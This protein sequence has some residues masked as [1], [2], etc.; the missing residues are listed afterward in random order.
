M[1]DSNH[2]Q[3]IILRY[4]NGES[5]AE[6]T[7]ELEQWKAENASHAEEF[8]LIKNI[9][10]DASSSAIISV[11]TEK[12]WSNVKTQ[13][14][15]KQT[16]VVKLFPWKRTLAV[17]ASLLLFVGVYY[18]YFK[19]GTTVW[20]ETL[21]LTDNKSIQLS[22]GTTVVLR[23][24][25]KLYIPDD[26][27]KRNRQTKLEGEAYFEVT[28]DAQIPFSVIT[29]RSIIKD[30]GTAFFVQS[31][32]RTEQVTVLE[33]IISYASKQENKTQL[34]LNAGESAAMEKEKPKKIEA[35]TTNILSWESKIL[36]FSNTPLAL[37]AEDLSNYYHIEVEVAAGI[38]STQITATF[39][40]ESL[41]QV[42]QELRL[43]SGLQFR[44]A[45][46]KLL[47]TK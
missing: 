5:S 22:D 39:K 20:T 19:Q 3:E 21:A 23:K 15:D 40:N 11:D 38:G 33:G 45:E 1:S 12:A 25:G 37:I 27:G 9:W 28:H 46:N 17:A 34:I 24:G 36:V 31:T 8:N 30:I 43:I 47:I 10:A 4:L 2:I 41:E 13:T 6:E 7:L 32:D 26:Y 29:T 42:L 44:L 16:K 35:D 14:I 18:I